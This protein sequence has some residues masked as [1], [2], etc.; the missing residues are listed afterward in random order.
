MDCKVLAMKQ[1]KDMVI[2]SFTSLS[3][4]LLSV[5][6][7]AD[8]L[9]SRDDS[10]CGA[11]FSLFLNLSFLSTCVAEGTSGDVIQGDGSALEWMGP[12]SN[13]QHALRNVPYAVEG[14]LK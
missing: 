8:P 7:R 5:L 6:S 3:V 4:N 11:L 9:S 10:F 13:D 2:S 14:P 12:T 1:Q